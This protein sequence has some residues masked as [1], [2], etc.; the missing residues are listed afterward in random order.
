MEFNSKNLQYNLI[1]D[2]N[3]R[4]KPLYYKTND[5]S[6]DDEII[7]EKVEP[8]DLIDNDFIGLIIGKQGYGKST[9]VSK[10]LTTDKLLKKKFHYILWTTPGKI[11]GFERNEDFWSDKVDMSWLNDRLER[12]SLAAQEKSKD[13]NVL[14]V[15]DDAIAQIFSGKSLDTFLDLMIR[16]RHKYSR[17]NLSF[18]FTTQYYKLFPKKY[19]SMLNYL[20]VFEVN[21]DDWNEIQKEIFGSTKNSLIKQVIPAHWKSNTHNFIFIN[22]LKHFYTLNFHT[23]LE[24]N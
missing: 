23:I 4:K 7:E 8:K 22:L 18:L 21:G 1:Q 24:Y 19:R 2:P 12:I 11:P 17:V 5:S 16:R 10:L 15:I 20:F 13:A 6:N 14:W 3:S 9:L